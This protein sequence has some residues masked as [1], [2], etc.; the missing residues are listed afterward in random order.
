MIDRRS[1]LTINLLIGISIIHF[2]V[3][4][5][6]TT[7]LQALYIIYII[8]SDYIYIY[9]YSYNIVRKFGWIIHKTNCNPFK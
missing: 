9:S 4:H 2:P 5:Y 7:S 8:A 6:T 1:L 3:E